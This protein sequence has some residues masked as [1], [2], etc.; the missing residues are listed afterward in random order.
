MIYFAIL[1]LPRSIRNNRQYVLLVGVI[2]G[3]Q[4][5]KRDINSFL[6]LI[7]D[8]LKELWDGFTVNVFSASRSMGIRTALLCV[9]CDLPA[10]RKLGGFLGHSA[11][12]GCSRCYKVFGGGFGLKDY[13]DFDCALWQPRSN[14]SHW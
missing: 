14:E 10:S 11:N 5:L 7:V 2:P 1:S 8:E 6:K 4:E 3:P 9:A 12:L 13:S